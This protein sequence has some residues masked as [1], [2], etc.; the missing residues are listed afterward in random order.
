MPSTSPGPSLRQHAPRAKRREQILRAALQ[1]FADKGLH[2]STMDDI[3]RAAGLSKGSLYWHF[4]SKEMVFLTLYEAF[5]LEMSGEWDGV[6]N[7]VADPLEVLRLQAELAIRA[8]SGNRKLLLAWTEFFTHPVVRE[9]MPEIYTLGRQMLAEVVERGRRTGAIAPGPDP[10]SVAATLLGAVEG[11]LLQYMMD[12]AFD[13]E[14]NF[15][16]SWTLLSR[17]LRP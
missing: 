16:A 8:F 17:G 4:D 6:A 11:L 3:A 7:E 10:Q 13:L 2:A 14:R 12:P 1:C 9:R 15:E 5:T